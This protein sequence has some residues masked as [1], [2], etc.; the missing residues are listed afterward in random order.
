MDTTHPLGRSAVT[1]VYRIHDRENLMVRWVISVIVGIGLF[2]VAATS[3]AQSRCAGIVEQAL[4]VVGDNCVDTSRNQACHG[5]WRVE[6]QHR[7]DAPQFSFQVGQ[8]ADISHIASLRTWPLDPATGEWGVALMQLQANMPNT[9]PG[10]NVTFLLF[11]DATLYDQSRLYEGTQ[12]MQI[13]RLETGLMGVQCGDAPSSGIL[14]QTP[15]G[16]QRANLTINGVNISLDATMLI[17]ARPNETMIVQALDGTVQVTA[18]EFMRTFHAGQQVEV[19]MSRDMLPT[20]TPGSAV[21]IDP[22]QLAY[23][24]SEI[25]ARPVAITAGQTDQGLFQGLLSVPTGTNQTTSPGGRESSDAASGRTGAS[26]DSA[27]AA[28]MVSL[29]RLAIAGLPV[30]AVITIGMLL[31]LGVIRMVRGSK[32]SDQPQ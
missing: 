17:Q 14:I 4:A 18:N 11:G 27:I 22:A 5:Y 31:L 26:S 12:P 6:A 29:S 1:L 8:L 32:R 24:P 25:L 23:V 15:E 28:F 3:V 20:G 19:A 21:N 16:V 30:M 7:S 13:V 9:L 10:Q 2:A